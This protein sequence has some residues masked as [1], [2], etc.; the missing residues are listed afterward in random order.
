MKSSPPH[1]AKERLDFH[2]PG[3]LEAKEAMEAHMAPAVAQGALDRK[4]PGLRFA[5]ST[6]AVAGPGGVTGVALAFLGLF[7]AVGTH[8]AHHGDLAMARNDG[9]CQS[10]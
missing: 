6:T 1:L 5:S 10:W 9:P 4:L 7:S 8:D 2:S 3:F